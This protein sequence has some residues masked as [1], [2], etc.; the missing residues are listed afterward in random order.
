MS[1]IT[2]EFEHYLNFL[3]NFQ[4]IP[5]RKYEPTEIRMSPEYLSSIDIRVKIMPIFLQKI[6]NE[7]NKKQ[8]SYDNYDYHYTEYLYNDSNNYN[9]FDFYNNS[10]L[11][12]EFVLDIIDF[13]ISRNKFTVDE[14][15]ICDKLKADVDGNIYDY[16]HIL[17][18]NNNFFSNM[19]FS[20]L[21]FHNS[22][23]SN[24]IL[25]YNL[26]LIAGERHAMI[27]IKNNIE[28][29][30]ILFD[31]SYNIHDDNKYRC[32]ID[33]FGHDY[34]MKLITLNVQNVESLY[35][36][37]FC[38]FW[39]YHFVYWLFINNVTPETYQL[40]FRETTTDR[41]YYEIKMFILKMIKSEE[42]YVSNIDKYWL[43]YLKYKQKY[44]K[45]KKTF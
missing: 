31:P 43:K 30:I 21:I 2:K 10:G 33:I 11:I 9:L 13:M 5:K 20:K 25:D 35:Q 29:E 16:I 24:N 45:L 34:S 39:C 23:K 28:R 1:G 38:Y 32:L 3:E 42:I 6:I 19:F 37:V 22:Y 14:L 44:L 15:L 40:M 17:R 36:D 27:I 8:L 41:Y 4:A 26:I 12:R 18:Q 7:L